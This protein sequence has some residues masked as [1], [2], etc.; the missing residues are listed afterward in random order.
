L[1]NNGTS[2]T[3]SSRSTTTPARTL[4]S[5]CFLTEIPL[6]LELDAGG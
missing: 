3:A 2:K 4:R 1:M 5:G 6:T